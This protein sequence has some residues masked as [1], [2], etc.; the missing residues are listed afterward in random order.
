MTKVFKAWFLKLAELCLCL[1]K[2][3]SLV[4]SLEVLK[5]RYATKKFDASKKIS[6]SDLDKLFEGINLSASS[7]GLQPFKMIHVQNES[8]R[9]KLREH[10]WNQSQVTDASD[11]IVFAG[12][13]CLPESE[14]QQLME[15]MA[16]GSG[17]KVEDMQGYAGLIRSKVASQEAEAYKHWSAKQAYIALGTALIVAA[18]LGLDTCPMEGLDPKAYDSELGLEDKQLY[19]HFALAV[20]Y[21][22]SD[23]RNQHFKKVRKPL[24]EML[25]TI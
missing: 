25:E 17:T 18:E 6:R 13:S 22:A 16:S 23:D 1:N 7:Y 24:S 10:S 4:K 20:G 5:W 2:R 15:R 9:A 3:R 12:Y 19:T 8:V 14:I 11:Y 21:R